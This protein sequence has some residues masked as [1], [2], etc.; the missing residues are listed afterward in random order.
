MNEHEK[1]RTGVGI[2]SALCY[3]TAIACFVMVGYMFPSDNHGGFVLMI[4]AAAFF[5]GGC[6]ALDTVASTRTK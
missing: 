3:I 6:V 5:V 2:L 4:V 1:L